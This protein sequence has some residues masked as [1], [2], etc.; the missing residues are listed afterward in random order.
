ML[1]GDDLY[2]RRTLIMGEVNTGKTRATFAILRRWVEINPTPLM[3]VL[4]LAPVRI[5]GVG[6]RLTLPRG[7]TGRY[8]FADIVP[9]RLTGRSAT[10]ISRL[11]AA[12]AQIVVPLLQEIIQKPHPILI[13]NDVT[14]YLQAGDDVLLWAALKSADTLLV[15]AYYGT[16]FADHPISQRERRLTDRLMADCDQ[17]IWMPEGNP[18]D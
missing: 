17:I 7:F 18:A 2:H 4:D 11:A 6:G 3:T 10:E 15:N 8:R 12:N 16:S 5:R 13:I 9:P 14:L 1:A